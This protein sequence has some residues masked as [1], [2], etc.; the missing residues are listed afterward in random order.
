[1]GVIVDYNDITENALNPEIA[2]KLMKNVEQKSK[3]G[4]ANNLISFF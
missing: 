2:L 4:K 1:M 3:N